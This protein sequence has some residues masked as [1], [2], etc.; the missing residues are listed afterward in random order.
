MMAVLMAFT[1]GGVCVGAAV[2]AR[3]KAQSAA[4]LAALAAAVRLVDGSVAACAQASV[5][6]VAMGTSVARCTV[7]DL[8]VAVTVEVP[9]SFGRTGFG[10]AR[11]SARAGPE[12]PMP[13]QTR[14][15]AR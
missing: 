8:D 9:V 11:A 14:T 1:I 6:A 7:E 10:L 3:H 15:A 2:I 5:V 4:D 12:T 13:V